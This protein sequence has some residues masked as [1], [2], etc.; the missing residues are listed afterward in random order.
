MVQTQINTSP[1]PHPENMITV[2]V[3][4]RVRHW[5][6]ST[7]VVT[8][9]QRNYEYTTE[10]PGFECPV[11]GV[12]I[13]VLADRVKRQRKPSIPARWDGITEVIA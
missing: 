3:G 4:D 2:S 12:H 5:S 9:I 13:I 10:L 8:S 1:F 7:G 11:Y 6:G